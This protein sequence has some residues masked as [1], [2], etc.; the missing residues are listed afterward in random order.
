M[1]EIDVL[2]PYT[3]LVNAGAVAFF[4]Q[5]V[6]PDFVVCEFGSGK[7][8]IWF[9]RHCASVVSVENDPRWFE[10]VG[11]KLRE[12]DLCAERYLMEHNQA[13]KKMMHKSRE[14]VS[15]IDHYPDDHFDL[16]FVDGAARPWCIR[17]ARAKVKPG[18]WLVADDLGFG[19]VK[20]ALWMLDGWECTKISGRVDGAIDGKPRTGTTGFFRKPGGR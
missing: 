12:L 9:A 10:A 18:G 16:V 17:D 13:D 14:Y 11:A 4:E 1:I 6:R 20:R 5:I 2:P 19:Y 3:P 7:S 8:T 15:I